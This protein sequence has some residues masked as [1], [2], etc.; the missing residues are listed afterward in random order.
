[1]YNALFFFDFLFNRIVPN[2][3][4]SNAGLDTSVDTQGILQLDFV[5]QVCNGAKIDFLDFFEKWGFLRPVD[6]TFNDYGN[7]NFT[8]TQKQ[9]D[10]LKAEIRAKGYNKAPE[11]LYL[12]TDENFESYKK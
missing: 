1:M 7:K 12:I 4:I 3:Y 9:I 10:D 8:V 11:N 2:L 6:K 5:R